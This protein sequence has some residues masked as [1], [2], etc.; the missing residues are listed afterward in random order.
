MS[1][2]NMQ[3][4]LGL[5]ARACVRVPAGGTLHGEHGKGEGDAEGAGE[6]GTENGPESAGRQS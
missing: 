5:S 6:E 3:P 4:H 2:G 1:D